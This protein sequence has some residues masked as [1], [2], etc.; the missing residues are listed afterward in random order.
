LLVSRATP[1]DEE[2]VHEDIMP[3]PQSK[4]RAQE[5]QAASSARRASDVDNYSPIGIPAVA[6]ATAQLRS[7]QLNEALRQAGL[8]K[9][10]PAVLRDDDETT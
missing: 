5:Q 9:D 4:P 7:S 2:T 1:G 6:A 3:A 8:R 10:T